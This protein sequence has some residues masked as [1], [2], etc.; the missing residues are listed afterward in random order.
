M[1]VSYRRE[2]DRNFLVIRQEEFEDQYQ[3]GMIVKN[4]IP[5]FLEC[6]LSSAPHTAVPPKAR[7]A[8]SPKSACAPEE[9]ADSAWK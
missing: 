7:K 3:V 9:G 6:S 1:K 5:G 2:L 4:K 8:P